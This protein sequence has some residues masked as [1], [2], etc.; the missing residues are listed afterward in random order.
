MAGRCG[1]PSFAFG[2]GPGLLP[3]LQHNSRAMNSPRIAV[4]A[5]PNPLRLCFLPLGAFHTLGL[6]S[7][8]FPPL[9]LE[10]LV[11]NRVYIV[12]AFRN[13]QLQAG[14][15]GIFAVAAKLAV[16]GR[17]DTRI[18]FSVNISKLSSLAI[19][20]QSIRASQTW[21]RPKTDKRTCRQFPD[22]SLMSGFMSM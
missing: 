10:C 5:S 14:A 11:N 12:P 8:E 6:R 7:L 1:F 9:R 4:F 15:P 16:H 19:K 18:D 2:E 13:S 22:D 17:G 20:L 3:L 21:S